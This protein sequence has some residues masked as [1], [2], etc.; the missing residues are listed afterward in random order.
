TSSAVVTPSAASP[1][2][3]ARRSGGP[4]RVSRA[5]ASHETAA[6]IAASATNTRRL[7]EAGQSPSRTVGNARFGFHPLAVVSRNSPRCFL[8]FQLY[9]SA[10]SIEIATRAVIRKR[11]DGVDQ[12][13]RATTA[14]GHTAR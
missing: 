13:R 14:I 4:S 5:K 8:W 2:D 1:G 3:S 12:S 6:R 11:I 7:A 9:A 10:V